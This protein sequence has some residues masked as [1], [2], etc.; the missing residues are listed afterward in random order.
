MESAKRRMGRLLVIGTL[1]V[2]P[3]AAGCGAGGDAGGQRGVTVS[4]LAQEQYF[5]QEPYLGRTVTVSAAVSKVLGPRVFTLS[6][7]DSGDD[8]LVVTGQPVKVAKGQVVRVTGTV[9][10][11]HHSAPSEGVP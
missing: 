8:V 10:Q 6:G 9:G 5:Y 11:V 1:V 2:V 7:A 3:V 4:D